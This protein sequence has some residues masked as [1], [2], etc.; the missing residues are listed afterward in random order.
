VWTNAEWRQPSGLQ[1]WA[2]FCL[3]GECQGCQIFLC[4]NIRNWEKIQQMTTNYTKWPLNIPNGHKIYHHL[5]IK[6]PPKFIQIW[7]FWFESKPSG[8]P[9]ECTYV[10]LRKFFRKK[11]IFSGV[12]LHFGRFFHIPVQLFH[13]TIF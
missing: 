8:N 9:G 2:N 4:P 3:L 1:D 7:D 10:S 6:G 11:H 5:P 12:W 13:G